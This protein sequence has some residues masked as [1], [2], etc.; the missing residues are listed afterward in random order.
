MKSLGN[1]IAFLCTGD[2]IINGEILD[3]N[4]PHFAER[5]IDTNFMP[6][7]RLVVSDDQNEMEKAIRYLLEDHSVLITIGGLGPTSDD[8]TRFA[9]SGALE[10]PLVFNEASWERIQTLLNRINVE[11]P[12]NNRQQCLFPENAEIYPNDH[13]T[14]S[15]CCIT[16]NDQ[17]IFMLPGP[18][19]ECRPIFEEHILPRLLKTNLQQTIHRRSWML[20][21][22]S[23]GK[24]AKALDAL[25]ENSGCDIGYRVS[26]PYLEVKLQSTDLEALETIIPTLEAKIQNRLISR[27]KRTASELFREYLQ[28]TKL[29]FSI[30]DEA[31]GGRLESTL[32]WPDLFQKVYFNKKNTDVKVTLEGLTEY[33]QA[34]TINTSDLK[35]NLEQNGK[36]THE[37]IPVPIRGMR[38]P[39]YAVELACEWLLA[40]LQL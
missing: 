10:E 20:L 26:Y 15:A 37:I 23:E 28:K 8:R 35:I 5:L 7:T 27:D 22:V 2:E 24:I 9:V 11:I 14:A 6:G 18:P 31:T 21:G 25:V 13:G 17:L 32:L 3:T 29:S 34:K 30:L 12:E 36:A 40:T 4:A 38:T 33:W 19:N 1:R 16:K 39:A